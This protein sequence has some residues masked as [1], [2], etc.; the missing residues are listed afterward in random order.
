MYKL[1]CPAHPRVL[2]VE[3]LK[4]AGYGARLSMSKPT[5]PLEGD[6]QRVLDEVDSL[7]AIYGCENVS[8]VHET[9]TLNVRMQKD[10]EIRMSCVLPGLYP[11]K[12]KPL[13]VALRVDG[14][15]RARCEEVVVRV[16]EAVHAGRD[17]NGECLFDYCHGLVESAVEEAQTISANI[18]DQV[19]GAASSKADRSASPWSEFFGDGTA[20]RHGEPLAEKKSV[21][22]AHAAEVHCVEA[23]QTFTT[24]LLHAFPKLQSASHQVMAYRI[25]PAQ[26]FD[27]D[28]ETGAG[29][30]LLFTLQQVGVENTVVVVTRWFGGTKLGPARFKLINNAARQLFSE[31]TR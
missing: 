31:N 28:G 18:R 8:F 3:T 20:V 24:W 4:N 1:A 21:F 10:P 26:D 25:G 9:G 22:Q 13:R 7:S 2:Y 29:K 12:E 16:I 23:A 27:D 11:S 5:E 19:E 30:G 15:V 6:K 17:S 14:M